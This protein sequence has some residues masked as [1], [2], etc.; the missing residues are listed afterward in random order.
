M[1]SE[2][3]LVTPEISENCQCGWLRL[4]S[5]KTVNL[6]TPE[7]SENSVWLRMRSLKTV[8]LVTH[9]VSKTDSYSLVLRYGMA[10]LVGNIQLYFFSPLVSFIIAHTAYA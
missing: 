7:I 8:S 1:I 4:R 6:V 9:E 5:L 10:P 2:V 3:N